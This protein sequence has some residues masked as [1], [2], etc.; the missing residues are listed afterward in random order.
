MIIF[1]ILVR[2]LYL[3]NRHTTVQHYGFINNESLKI[4]QPPF[5]FYLFKKNCSF[6][7]CSQKQ[8]FTS[9]FSSLTRVVKLALHDLTEY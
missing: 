3:S 7:L 9:E 8:P 5:P 1:Q 6:I 4:N 2:H